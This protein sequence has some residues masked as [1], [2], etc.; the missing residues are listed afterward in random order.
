MNRLLH[1]VRPWPILRTFLVAAS[2]ALLAVA[3][4]PAQTVTTGNLAGIVTDAQGGVVARCDDHCSPHADRNQ[5]RDGHR[6]RGPLR[7]PE[8]PRRAPMT[9]RG[10]GGLQAADAD[11]PRG[12]LWRAGAGGLQAAGRGG[13]R[14]GRS[15]G[16][17]RRLIDP[18]APA[19]RDN[20]SQRCRGIAPDHHP[21]H[22]RHR[23]HV[24]AT[25]TRTAAAP[26]TERRSFRWRARTT[27]TTT[28]RSTARSTTTCSAWR[29]P[30]RPAARPKRS[31]SA[32][33]PSRNCSWSSR[34]TTCA[35][36]ASRAAASTPSPRAAPTRFSG[37]AF[38]FGR[39]QSWV[40]DGADR[41]T[42]LATFKDKQF[43]GSLG[44]P[45]VENKAFFFG[46]VDFGRK[47]TP[48]GF[49][50]SGVGPA[51]RPRRLRCNRFLDILQNR[52]GYDPGATGRVHPR[53]PTAT[54]SSCA[55]DFNL[56]QQPPADGPPQLR[57]RAERHRPP[58]HVD[59]LHARTASTGSTARPTR[60]SAS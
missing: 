34:P 17:D 33:T 19:R 28:S 35:R 23:A 31:R 18:R 11:R 36:A 8:R 13:D 30:A 58:S 2:C 40:G 22:R 27:A 53:R 54:S 12:A 39:N 1:S 26:T 5:L 44:G 25:S 45:I 55:T 43:G 9:S 7:H 32:S 46:N 4:A 56:G 38:Y 51:V 42:D 10:D 3:P 21:Q 20:V 52:Y 37:T 16:L 15:R 59:V 57:R 60:R 48:S 29:D 6:R 41:S 24:A 50:V 14:N 47:D 49:S